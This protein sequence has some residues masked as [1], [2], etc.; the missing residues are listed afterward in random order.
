MPIYKF[1][2]NG[3]GVEACYH[4][5]DI[6]KLFKPIVEEILSIKKSERVIV[7]IA[8][9]PGSGKS[10]LAA[11]FAY[12]SAG[13]I[14]AVGM[15]GFHYRQKYLDKTKIKINSNWQLLKEIKGSP[16]TFDVKKLICFI[17]E[18]KKE[19]KY[20]PRYDRTLH[21]V[22]DEGEFISKKYVII[23]GNYMLYNENNYKELH[24]H[25]DRSIFIKAKEEKIVERLIQ[26]KIKGNYSY[27]DARDFVYN[28][29]LKNIVKINE[30]SI[31]ADIV[32]NVKEDRYN[33]ED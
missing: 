24:Q 31:K 9:P 33:K 16:E 11:Y 20:W 25:C 5:E 15:D 14:Q 26:R 21:D 30:N 3:F 29:D 8:G 28:S 10:T 22:V 18:I 27:Q 4:Q 19:N 2:I 12:L 1:N 23:E 6:D 32:L 17:K 13:Q 7:Y